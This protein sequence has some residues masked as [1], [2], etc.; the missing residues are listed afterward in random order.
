MLADGKTV[1]LGDLPLIE[2][3]PRPYTA[4]P[5]FSFTYDGKPSAELL[6]TWHV[7]AERAEARRP[8]HRAHR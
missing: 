3:P 6:T 2:P 4:E 5:P 1:W 8:A 7:R